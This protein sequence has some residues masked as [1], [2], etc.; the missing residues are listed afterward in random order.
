MKIGVVGYG[1]GNVRS[2]LNAFEFLGIDAALV[3]DPAALEEAERIVLPGVGA[4]GAAM[5]RLEVTGFH[6]ALDRAVRRQGKP[7]LGICLGMQLLAESS[8]EFG[9]H[10]GL[11]FLKGRVEK[12]PVEGR[13]RVLPHMGWN[14][15]VVVRPTPLLDGVRPDPDF[16]FV[17][18][19]HIAPETTDTIDATVDY[20]TPVTAMVSSGNVMGTQF[21]PEKS[22]EAG[23]KLLASFSSLP[24]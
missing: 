8:T 12:I 6:D 9:D 13:G 3:T 24:C 18:S 5:A 23:L 10:A 7:L 19:F 15:L 17:H 21:H 11:G 4:F 2:V 16:Y 1:M 14:S 20:G 22:Q